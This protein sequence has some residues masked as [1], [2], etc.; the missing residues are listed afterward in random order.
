MSK[1]LS[2]GQKAMFFASLLFG[3]FASM[4]AIAGSSIFIAAAMTAMD[5]LTLLGLAFTLE[6]LFRCV[7]IPLS[8]KLGERYLRRTLFLVGLV[9]FTAG[10]VLCAVAWAPVVILVARAIMGL[11]WGLFF[12]NIVVMLSDVYPPETAPKMNG[13]MQT[14][15]FI[16]ALAAAPVAGLFVD[17]LSWQ[18]ALYVT[19]AAAAI[20]FVLML[21][22][23][24]VQERVNDGKKLD[25]GGALFLALVL[26]PFSLA[27]S[28][29]GTAYQWNDPIIIGL[30][31]ATVVFL[32][33]LIF[34]ERKAQDPII[35]SHLFG[36]K[37]YMM[38]FFLG[39]AFSAICSSTLFLPTILQ[40]GMGVSATESSLPAAANSLLCIIATSFIGTIFA[41][42]Q[43]AKGLVA[44]ETIIVLVV[45]AVLFM[46]AP[47]TPLILVAV[48][49]G[50]LGIAQ[51]VHQVVTFSYPAVA[52]QPSEIAVGVAFISFGQICSGTVF[53][54]VLGALM[55]AD[56]FMPLRAVAVF[57]VVM[58]ICV[59][60]FKDRKAA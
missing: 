2:G 38:I 53:N 42:T 24:N 13:F 5:G 34:V 45:G 19:I 57:G 15:G 3:Y 52:M 58:L 27:L 54:A 23:P 17:F 56:I 30:F 21:L 33:I 20:S 4:F 22:V 10:G 1:T 41:K 12:S 16:A 14:F 55:N 59:L 51:A 37:N 32:I 49:Y 29:G 18:W 7:T 36:N 43:K 6:S 26:V 35:P 9:L 8:A 39:V 44:V 25:L 50:A 11:A 47:G 48:L 31:A 40:Q 28:W 60:L 46:V